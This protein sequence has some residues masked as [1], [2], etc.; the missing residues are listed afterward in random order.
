MLSFLNWRGIAALIIGAVVV[1]VWLRFQFLEA[2]VEKTN[3]A[4]ADARQMLAAAQAQN[5]LTQGAVHE[6]DRSARLERS[7]SE[8]VAASDREITDAAQREDAHAL[9]VAWVGSIGRLRDAAA[10]GMA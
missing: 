10:D 7:V 9:Y 3:A 6:A 8:I 4:L 1:S 5:R 2:E